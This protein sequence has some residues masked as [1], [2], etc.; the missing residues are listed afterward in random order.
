MQRTKALTKISTGTKLNNIHDLRTLFVNEHTYI[1]TC[2]IKP[3]GEGGEYPQSVFYYLCT[4]AFDTCNN[5]ELKEWMTG[6]NSLMPCVPYILFNAYCSATQ[7]LIRFQR[8]L[9][10]QGCLETRNYIGLDMTRIKGALQIR[11]SFKNKLVEEVLF[12]SPWLDIPQLTPPH[13]CPKVPS[14]PT[15]I[16]V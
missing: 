11:K 8:C 2:A 9:T 7:E 16:R 3:Q 15:H 5:Q 13:N 6:H 12:N 10:T 14:A 4:N 1:M